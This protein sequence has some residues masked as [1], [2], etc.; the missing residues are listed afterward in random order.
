MI[1]AALNREEETRKAFCTYSVISPFIL[2]QHS[3]S[4]NDK[5]PLSKRYLSWLRPTRLWP[6]TFSSWSPA[7][8]LPFCGR[9]TRDYMNNHSTES[10]HFQFEFSWIKRLHHFSWS[11]LHN[12]FDINPKVVLACS[13]CHCQRGCWLDKMLI[14]YF[15]SQVNKHNIIR[16]KRQSGRTQKLTLA[17]TM[18]IPI[19]QF[20]GLFRVI[21]TTS[22]SLC[23]AYMM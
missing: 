16:K 3:T 11:P 21:T 14:G 19:P 1:A 6:S 17:A 9:V 10:L 20:R 23:P 18:L 7:A 15:I 8:N 13:L 2:Q 4:L 12:R 5:F 22:G